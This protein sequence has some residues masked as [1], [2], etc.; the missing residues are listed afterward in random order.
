MNQTHNNFYSKRPN[1]NDNINKFNKSSK[2]K[3]RF[4]NK[5]TLLKTFSP[6]SSNVQNLLV[7]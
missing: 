4:I 5:Y 7:N 1:I 2:F 6:N 3:N